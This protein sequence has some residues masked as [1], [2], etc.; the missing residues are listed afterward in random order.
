MVHL[1]FAG[2]EM[3]ALPEAALY[4]P[5]RRALLLAD[6]HFEKA[7]WFARSGQM[8]PPYDSMATLEALE[9]LVSRTGA[10]EIWCLGDSF[11]DSHGP[12]RLPSDIVARLAS[13]TARLK[14]TWVTGNHDIAMATSAAF[15]AL[16]GDIVPEAYV[17]GILLRHAAEE[18]EMRPEISGHYHPKIRLALRGRHVA[19][20]CF[21]TGRNRIILPAFGALTGG[22]DVGH[23]AIRKVVGDA[24]EALVPLLN[25]LLRFPLKSVLPRYGT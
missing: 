20:A 8:L 9:K 24:G 13:L 23:E 18:G 17:D 7:S 1:S 14:W 4:W 6:I 15:A 3:Q 16:G 5:A 10:Q 11:H 19:R 21:V 12:A 22:L 2:H 25:Q